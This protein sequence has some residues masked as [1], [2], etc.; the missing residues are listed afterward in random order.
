MPTP[1]LRSALFLVFAG[2]IG[3]TV[4]AFSGPG[5]DGSTKVEVI[6]SRQSALVSVNIVNH[7]KI[8]NVVIEVRDAKG[9][10]LYKEEGKALTPELVRR[11][12]KGVFPKGQL[13]L[14][15]T[16]RDFSVTR[17]LVIE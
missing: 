14:S 11:L 6:A 1:M 16:A 4:P 10:V 5:K 8:G 15:V 7:R 12:D 13:T 17:P 3:T 2:L 9:V